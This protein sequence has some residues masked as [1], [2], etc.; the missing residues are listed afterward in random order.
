M[1]MT[2]VKQQMGEDVVQWKIACLTCLRSWVQ[3][4]EPGKKEKGSKFC[5][6]RAKETANWLNDGHASIRT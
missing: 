2:T 4:P 3:F 1:T 5:Y 6:S